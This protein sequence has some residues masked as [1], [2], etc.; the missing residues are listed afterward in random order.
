MVFNRPIMTLNSSGSSQQVTRPSAA[1]LI[2]VC[3]S[4]KSKWF[5]IV[6]KSPKEQQQLS[7]SSSNLRWSSIITT[8]ISKSLTTH[9]SSFVHHRNHH[10]SKH[11]HQFTDR[12]HVRSCDRE[13]VSRAPNQRCLANSFQG[14][15]MLTQWNRECIC[16]LSLI[17]KCLGHR[18]LRQ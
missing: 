3:P 10:L 18:H 8:S 6:A 13:S 7:T 12:S 17:A 2:A 11:C 1:S 16:W 9:R 5:L 4:I 15:W 14:Q